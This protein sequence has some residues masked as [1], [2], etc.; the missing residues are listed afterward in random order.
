M[1]PKGLGGLE[2]GVSGFGVGLR[3]ALMAHV[4]MTLNTVFG[5]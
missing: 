4:P 3:E 1:G 5:R 2:L